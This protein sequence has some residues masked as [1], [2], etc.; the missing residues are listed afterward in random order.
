MFLGFSDT[1]HVL[2]EL[3]AQD[4]VESQSS[5]QCQLLDIYPE[6]ALVDIVWEKCKTFGISEGFRK[7]S[8]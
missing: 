5:W 3:V 2:V 7:W 6:S 8:E 4:Q 1:L